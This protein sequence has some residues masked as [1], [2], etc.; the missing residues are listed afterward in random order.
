[1]TKDLFLSYGGL[2]EYDNLGVT[3]VYPAALLSALPRSEIQKD[4]AE[5]VKAF[6]VFC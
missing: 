5:N 4:S 2:I 3:V 1:M 6:D